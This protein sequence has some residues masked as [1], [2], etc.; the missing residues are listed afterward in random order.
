MTSADFCPITPHVTAR[1]AAPISN[2]GWGW[3]WGLLA[4]SWSSP[5]N[6]A[7]GSFRV[8]LSEAGY[9][10]GISIVKDYVHLIRP[11]RQPAFL[12]LDFEP[13]ECAQVDR[14]LCK[15]RHRPHYAEPPHMPS[16]RTTSQARSGRR[17][18]IYSA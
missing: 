16:I 10:G 15:Y 8:R 7:P 1:R 11:R 5:P 9:A 3:G 6:S 13:G 4:S 2:W 18:L 14:G 17:G 12:K